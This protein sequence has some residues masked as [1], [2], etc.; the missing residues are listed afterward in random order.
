[1]ALERKPFVE[2]LKD[3]SCWNKTHTAIQADGKFESVMIV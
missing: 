2:K 3:V 1:M